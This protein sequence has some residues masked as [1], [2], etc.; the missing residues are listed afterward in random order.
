MHF[1]CTIFNMNSELY[2]ACSKS[3]STVKFLKTR[4]CSTENPHAMKATFI[5]PPK[6]DYG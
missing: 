3:H 2:I 4:L 1:P 6:L 5:S